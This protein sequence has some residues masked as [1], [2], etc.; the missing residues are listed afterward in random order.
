MFSLS[1]SKTIESLFAISKVREGSVH[2]THMPDCAMEHEIVVIASHCP[3]L[4]RRVTVHLGLVGRRGA[5][6]LV[7]LVWPT[8]NMK[9]MVNMKHM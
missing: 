2:A 9:N 8:V 6:V 4:V 1:I 7:V 3:L 5:E